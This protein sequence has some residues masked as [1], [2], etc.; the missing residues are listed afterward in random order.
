MIES[1]K[2]LIRDSVALGKVIEEYAVISTLETNGPGDRG[3]ALL[4][5]I[6]QLERYSDIYK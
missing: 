4:K 1:L 2:N 3:D 5:E 6:K